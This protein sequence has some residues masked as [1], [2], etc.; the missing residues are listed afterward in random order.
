M[1]KKFPGMQERLG[2]FQQRL[3]QKVGAQEANDRQIAEIPIEELRPAPWNARRYFNEDLIARLGADLKKNGQIQA[4]VVRHQEDAFEIVVGNR[5][6]HAAS[7]AGLQ[8]LRAEIWTLDDAAAR[9]LSLAENLQ[10]EDINPY[11]ETLG[12]TQLLQFLLKDEISFRNFKH[13]EETDEHAIERLLRRYANEI[14]R[15]E[16]NVILTTLKDQAENH[17]TKVQILGTPM[18]ALLLDV[19]S[20]AGH[21]TPLSFIKNRLPLLKMPTDVTS[22]VQSGKLD[23]TK[24]RKISQLKDQKARQALLTDVVVQ[25][26]SL[27]EVTTRVRSGRNEIASRNINGLDVLASRSRA[28]THAIRRTRALGDKI[29]LKKA[30]RLVSELEALLEIRAIDKE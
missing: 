19:F 14:E 18:E 2:N 26:L 29:K 22:A 16:N 21:M 6:F 7:I 3:A 17:T 9:Y 20:T 27:E 25:G 8:T 10:R 5:R 15:S 23:Y 24:A 4:I 12:Y 30:Q 1:S 28:I 11:E 13:P